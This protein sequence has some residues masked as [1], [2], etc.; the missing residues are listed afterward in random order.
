MID[1]NKKQKN[2][3]R[4][5]TMCDVSV[6]YAT[7]SGKSSKK[8]L[9]FTFSEKAVRMICG[10]G[11]YA[12]VGVD[13]YHP[14]RIYFAPST[15]VDGYKLTRSKTHLRYSCSFG[16]GVEYDNPTSFVGF[17]SLEY[18]AKQGA[19]YINRNNKKQED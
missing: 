13:K 11:H 5:P 17:Y 18:D 6:T 14:D 15:S 2:G 8:T 1:F 19:L 16:Y 4:M 7:R 12:V 10:E 9:C 3:G